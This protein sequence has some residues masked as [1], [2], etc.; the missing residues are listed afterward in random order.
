MFF[1]GKLLKNHIRAATLLYTIIYSG[2]LVKNLDLMYR[3]VRQDG[4]NIVQ[5]KKLLSNSDFF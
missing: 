1:A 2:E 3:F 5:K 4:G